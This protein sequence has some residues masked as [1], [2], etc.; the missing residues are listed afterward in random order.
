VKCYYK[1]YENLIV[2]S[3]GLNIFNLLDSSS[4]SSVDASSFGC[5]VILSLYLKLNFVIYS[6]IVGMFK[7]V[8]K[9][10]LSIYH[11]AFTIVRR[12]LFW[13]LCNI[14]ILELLAVPQRVH[15]MSRWASE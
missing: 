2:K 11:G 14:A 1:S 12:T 7:S 6:L 5:V 15:R 4:A 8:C 3:V 9:I 10:L 13:Y